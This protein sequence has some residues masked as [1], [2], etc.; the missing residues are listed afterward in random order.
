MRLGI[1][2]DAAWLVPDLVISVDAQVE[3]VHFLPRFAPYDV[4]AER[5]AVAAL[6][7]L[8]AMGAR[9][10]AMLSSLILPHTLD[11][12]A[13][14][15]VHEGLARAAD[16]YAAPVV[17]GNLAAGS[18][19]SLS[20]TVLGR[21]DSPLLRS[22][23]GVYVT[24]HVG[25]HALGLRAL[26]ADRRDAELA[27]FV[28]A[29]LHPTARIAEGLALRGLA[30]TC[31][32]VSDGLLADLGHVLAASQVGA[33]LELAALPFA[34]DFEAA[35]ALLGL[36]PLVLALDGGEAYELVFTAAAAPPIDATRIGTIRADR[37][38]VLRS[39]DGSIRA[40]ASAGFDHFRA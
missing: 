15:R 21:T 24:G 31:I 29:W 1:G 4:L 20:T 35:C 32:D 13:L 7:D 2:D 30:S 17:G 23:D 22:G 39:A 34:P 8:A 38:V 16:R 40:H 3:G 12:A 18:E 26:L 33:E 36:D 28:H 27:P 19:L 37:S 11:D 9:P 6:S 25:A 5:A 10:L 14:D